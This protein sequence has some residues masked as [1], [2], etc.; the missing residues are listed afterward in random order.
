MMAYS[1][2]AER[3]AAMQSARVLVS[4]SAVSGVA[5]LGAFVQW[6]VG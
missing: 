6:I 4:L 1:W 2:G 3:R 5:F